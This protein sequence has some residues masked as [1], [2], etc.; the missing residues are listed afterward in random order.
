MT[1]GATAGVQ[2]RRLVERAD[3]GRRLV[4]ES[5]PMLRV[6]LEAQWPLGAGA[7]RGF[8]SVASGELDYDGQTQGGVPL[9]SQ[10]GHRDLEAGLA[11]RPGP[12][13]RWGEG[14]LLL[15][16]LEQ[17]RQI[18]ST[19]VAGGLRET[20]RMTLTGV[21]WAHAFEAASWRWRPTAEL[22]V[23]LHH[24]LFVD[25]GGVFDAARLE[26][27]RRWDAALALDA[28]APQSAWSWGLEWRHARQE[29][30]ARQFVLRN[31]VPTGT[32][33]QPRIEIDDL[34]LRVRRSF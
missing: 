7:V 26:G 15:H 32:V 13:G 19:P 17:R 27:G 14:W 33:R 12:G 11:W 25:F 21:R 1:W 18:A 10:T 8:A 24:G 2:Q 23:A 4:E 3:D 22:R 5:G 28:S 16:L 30:S 29:A 20:S 31:G 34:L 6:A 9:R